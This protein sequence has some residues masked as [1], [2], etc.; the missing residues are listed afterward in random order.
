[1]DLE[2]VYLFLNNI[3]FLFKRWLVL[4][5]IKVSYHFYAVLISKAKDHFNFNHVRD[6]FIENILLY[7]KLTFKRYSNGST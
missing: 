4:F 2:I 5:L 3:I 7:Y 6:F 1:M